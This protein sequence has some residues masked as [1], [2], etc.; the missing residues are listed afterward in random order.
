MYVLLAFDGSIG[1]VCDLSS[2]KAR[3]LR[4]SVERARAFVFARE[5]S[6]IREDFVH[7][8][9]GL[10]VHDGCEFRSLSKCRSAVIDMLI[11]TETAGNTFDVA[12]AS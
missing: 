9:L 10:A 11:L 4:Y 2:D 1:E 6:G 8:Y 7:V 5:C 3:T 12:F